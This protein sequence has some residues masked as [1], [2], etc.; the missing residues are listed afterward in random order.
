MAL[1]DL[2]LKFVMRFIKADTLDGQSFLRLWKV[3]SVEF[4]NFPTVCL[5][6]FGWM[7]RHNCE[8]DAISLEVRI[9]RY[10]AKVG[11]LERLIGRLINVFDV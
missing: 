10:F 3:D 6:H 9:V 1:F 4:E 11:L 8:A 7:F 5:D 2:R